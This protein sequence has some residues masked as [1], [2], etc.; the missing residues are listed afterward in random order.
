MTLINFFTTEEEKDRSNL[1]FSL[2]FSEREPLSREISHNTV[3]ADCDSKIMEQGNNGGV[4]P[5]MHRIMK[6]RRTKENCQERDDNEPAM[7]PPAAPDSAQEITMTLS[8]EGEGSLEGGDVHSLMGQSRDQVSRVNGKGMWRAWTQSFDKP[9]LALL[10]LVDNSVD[11]SWSLLS[12]PDIYGKPKI[13][14]K[15]DSV[16]GEEE[17]PS[18]LLLRNDPSLEGGSRG[19]P[20]L[21]TEFQRDRREWYWHQ[22]CMRITIKALLCLF[23]NEPCI[24]LGHRYG[25]IAEGRRNSP[26]VSTMGSRNGFGRSSQRDGCSA[27]IDM[28]LCASRIW[29]WIRRTRHREVPI[30]F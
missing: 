5:M 12:M 10:D 23:E 2:T 9:L 27:Q 7:S 3:H 29:F 18:G 1:Y 6:D 13:E 4:P 8:Q 24:W 17:I 25:S 21:E 14:V 26:P 19:V 15:L 22:A 30:P 16:A 11:A 28:G 20:F